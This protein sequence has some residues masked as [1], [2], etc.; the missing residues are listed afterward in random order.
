MSRPL[1][2]TNQV[3]VATLPEQ[4]LSTP[5]MTETAQFWRVV[6][7]PS[8]AWQ[9]KWLRVNILWRYCC[10]SQQQLSWARFPALSGWSTQIQSVCLEAQRV[11]VGSVAEAALERLSGTKINMR[12]WWMTTCTD[13]IVLMFDSDA[14]RTSLRH[15]FGILN[16]NRSVSV[17]NN[18]KLM[19]WSFSS[20]IFAG[21]WNRSF[22]FGR[23]LVVVV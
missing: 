6:R 22:V 15:S 14:L 16:S 2:L 11:L 18:V 20:I 9:D 12:P 23:N 19:L 17:M 21:S 10:V 13:I 5:L 8:L 3:D 7:M 4:A 1:W